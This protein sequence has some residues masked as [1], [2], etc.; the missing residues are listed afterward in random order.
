[1]GED[2]ERKR[3]IL[4]ATAEL[5]LRIGYNKLTMGDVA[6]AVTLHR[7]L[8]YLVFKSKDEL[9]EAVVHDQLRRYADAWREHLEADPRAGSVASVY[10]AMMGALKTLPLAAAIV[11]RAE[12]VFGKYLRKRGSVF[13]RLPEISRSHDFL[14]AMQAAGAVH[15][16]VDVRA[17]AYILDALTPAIRRTFQEPDDGDVPPSA[18]VLAVLEKMIECT[19]PPAKGADLAAGK[20]I[21]LNLLTSA[22]S[23]FN[24]V[25]PGT[26]MEVRS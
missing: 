13:E 11:A 24:E 22:R 7:G 15:R 26:D 18:T 3:T 9:V 5:L 12:D 25:S 14:R 20:A 4:D 6:D 1:M 2:R 23:E 19:L 8:V 21:L 17:A 16:D 10:R